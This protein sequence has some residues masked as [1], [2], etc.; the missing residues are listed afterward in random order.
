MKQITTLAIVIG[1]LG[2]LSFRSAQQDIRGIWKGAYGTENTITET[3]VFFKKGNTVEI[4]CGNDSATKK[5]KGIYSLTTNNEITITYKVPGKATRLTMT[6]K[7]NPSKNFVDGDWQVE[8]GENGSFY[9]HKQANDDNERIVSV[10]IVT[11]VK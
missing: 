11:E 8:N 10:K 7:L 3:V 6:G 5:F 9:F 2:L 1:S 4:Y